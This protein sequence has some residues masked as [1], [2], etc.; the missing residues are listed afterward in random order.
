MP[1]ELR[2]QGLQ[3]LKSLLRTMHHRRCNRVIQRH[4]RPQG[5]AHQQF[6]KRKNLRPVCIFRPRRF[7]MNRGNGGLQLIGSGNLRTLSLLDQHESLGNEG[8]VPQA[9]VL[10]FQQHDVAVRIEARGCA[11]ML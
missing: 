8:A 2:I 7:V 11:C 3:Q 9:A 10:V 1:V 6:V 5:H 4:H